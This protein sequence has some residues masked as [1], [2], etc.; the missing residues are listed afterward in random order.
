MPAGRFLRGIDAEPGKTAKVTL[1]VEE[2][3][4]EACPRFVPQGRVVN[5]GLNGVAPEGQTSQTFTLKA[6]DW[7]GSIEQ[8]IYVVR[9]WSRIRPRHA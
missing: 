3:G 2:N 6:E 1:G 4:F 9:T 8:P 5:L 7:A